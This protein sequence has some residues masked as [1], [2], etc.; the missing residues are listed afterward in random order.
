MRNLLTILVALVCLW[1]TALMA[2]G[3]A[4]EFNGTNSYAWAP[5]SASLDLSTGMT[6]EAW[7]WSDTTVGAHVIA[8][9]WNDST[10][11][12]SYIFKDHNSSDALRIELS[13]GGHSDLAN[14]EGA[15]SIATGEWVHVAAT[16]DGSEVQLYYN[17]VLDSTQAVSGTINDSNSIFMVGAVNGWSGLE[18]FNGLIDE[19]RVWN[20]ARS[21]AEIQSTM[22]AGL[23]GSEGGLVAY[24]NFDEVLDQVAR[25]L[26]GFGNDLTLGATAGVDAN[27]PTWVLSTAPV[28]SAPAAPVPEP[29]TLAL[30]GLGVIG[31]GL[32]NRNRRI[33]CVK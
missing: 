10:R 17:G 32:F 21:E 12:W 31:L 27:D 30:L 26:S 24:Y 2:D 25:D 23:S 22:N 7:V 15:T 11:Q 18:S 9:K 3:F 1:G 33:P 28:S 13:Q 6:I 8:S 5:D 19:V 14:L 16:F 20:Y 29:C 4:L